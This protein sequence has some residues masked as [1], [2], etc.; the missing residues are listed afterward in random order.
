MNSSGWAR[1][2]PLSGV[3]FVI[4][5]LA[6]MFVSSTPDSSDPAETIAVFRRKEVLTWIT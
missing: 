4:V 2:S 3:A 5:Y 6:G 1:W